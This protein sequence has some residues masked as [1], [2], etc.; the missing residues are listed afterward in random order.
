MNF[1]SGGLSLLGIYF[2]QSKFETLISFLVCLKSF[3]TERNS[4]SDFLKML[5]NYIEENTFPKEFLFQL[6]TLFNTL[7][8]FKNR[9]D[10]GGLGNSKE[11]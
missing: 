1:Y 3:E 9:L 2:H 10:E 5:K 11:C 8:K 4:Y 7:L 6:Q